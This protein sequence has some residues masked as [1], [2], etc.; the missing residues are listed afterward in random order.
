MDPIL[1]NFLIDTPALNLV[2]A[3]T[4]NSLSTVCDYKTKQ[5][6]P[7]QSEHISKGLISLDDDDFYSE[8]S[9]VN[10]NIDYYIEDKFQNNSHGFHSDKISSSISHNNDIEQSTLESE[11]A[12]IDNITRSGRRLIKNYIKKTLIET[13]DPN[14]IVK[15]TQ[16]LNLTNSF[17]ECVLKNILSIMIHCY[18]N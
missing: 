7:C 9:Q 12:E 15:H 17:I 6:S 13:Q 14:K 4:T 10:T 11:Q 2:S 5:D 18:K 8:D 16:S 1:K 3:Y